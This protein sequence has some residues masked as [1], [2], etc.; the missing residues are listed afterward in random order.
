MKTKSITIILLF[1]LSGSTVVCQNASEKPTAKKNAISVEFYQPIQNSMR[2][3]YNDDWIVSTY[4]TEK[5]N[6]SRNSFSNAFGISYERLKKNNVF[7]VRLGVTIRDIKEHEDF[8]NFNERDDFS[9][10]VSQ[11]FTYKQNHINFFVGV[12]KRIHIATNFD[13]D[14][15]IDLASVYYL[16]AKSLYD[17]NIYQQTI[18]DDRFLHQQIITAE[19]RIGNMYGLG[20]GP[21]FKPQ[22]AIT[23][24]LIVAAE[25]QVYFMTTFTNDT[26]THKEISDNRDPL[27]GLEHLEF[28]GDVHYDV[29][30]WNWTKISPLIRI[31][32]QF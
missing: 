29:N 28:T 2:E 12:A 24:N 26:S 8:V 22:Y 30:Q 14:L 5:N 10:N 23:K 6:Y 4:P 18:S 7:R 1:I 20:L 19:D 31:G 21:V 11:D 3:F 15:G 32:Y 13:L 9:T 16:R 27:Y 17:Y 25:L